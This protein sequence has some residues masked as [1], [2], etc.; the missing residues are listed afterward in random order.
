M[1]RFCYFFSF[2]TSLSATSLLF[3][4]D[5][6]IFRTLDRQT[7]DRQTFRLRSHQVYSKDHRW[8]G[9]L[10][11]VVFQRINAYLMLWTINRQ[12]LTFSASGQP[13]TLII[14]DF[15]GKDNFLTY[16]NRRS[17]SSTDNFKRFCLPP[18][19]DH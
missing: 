8:A 1:Y 14:Y 12:L 7:G 17:I 15:S 9:I 19:P 6:Y 16:I 11:V 5:R 18:P 2:L 13:L 3:Y 4:T 10:S